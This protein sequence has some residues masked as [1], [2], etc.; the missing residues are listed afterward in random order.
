MQVQETETGVCAC[1]ALRRAN[2]AVTQFY[3]L[4]LAP[5]RLKTTQFIALR[6]IDESGELAQCEFAREYGMAVETL[7]RRLGGLRIKGLVQVRIGGRHGERI[8]SLTE[9]GKKTLSEA[10]PY[11][12]RAQHRLH[13]AL[14]EQD[15][16][17]LL[18]LADRIS[19]AAR[20]A[21]QLRT[22]NHVLAK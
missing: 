6:A 9:Q 13:S 20:G 14:G 10:F 11:W 21:E 1:A 12:D 2:R 8:Y 16:E 7:S 4:V 5:A 19:V 3:D 18:Q 15:W 17:T 22:T